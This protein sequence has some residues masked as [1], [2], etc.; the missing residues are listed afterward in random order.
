MAVTVSTSRPRTASFTLLGALYIA[1][2][3]PFGFFTLAL[4]SILRASGLSLTAISALGFLGLPWAVK[5]LWAPYVDHVGCRRTWLLTLQLSAVVSA[6]L[7]SQLPIESGLFSVI[8]AAFV[9]SVIA[10]TQ[11]IATDG[12]AI[13]ALDAR[14]RGVANALQVG[15]YR[16]GMILGGGLLLIIFDR[17]SWSIMFLC[18]SGLLAL[19]T[20]PVLAAPPEPTTRSA[21]TPKFAALTLGWWQRLMQPG[22]L[23]FI[24]L[25]ACFRFGDAMVS[26]L[27]G[28]FITDQRVPLATIG[29]MKGTVGSAASLVGAVLGGW[30]TAR[31]GRRF[32]V[33]ASGIAQAITFVPY[34]LVAL[35]IGGVGLLWTATLVEGVIGTMATVALFT[36]MMDASDPDHASTDY[37]L[38]ACAHVIVS[39]LGG[40]TAGVVGDVFGYPILF[41]VGTALAVGGTLI[42]VA[43][44]DRRPAPARVAAVWSS[45][46]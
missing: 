35:G 31:V 42:L 10:A 24:G 32:A 40:L 39:F 17:T 46:R 22:M 20:V 14:E 27:L 29:L 4:P 41:S 21:P 15:A 37:T 34:L 7:L 19:L 33:L 12:L 3:L 23:G 16:I 2:G 6:L 9:F 18:M 43:V 38:F 13:R 26:S 45:E 36:L 44:L 5:F 30:F 25:I 11:D 8:V 28:P 1:Q